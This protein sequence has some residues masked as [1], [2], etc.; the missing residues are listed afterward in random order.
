MANVTFLIDGNEVPVMNELD[1]AISK[2]IADIREPDKRNTDFSNT[3]EL[4][5]VGDVNR[6]FEHAFKVNIAHQTFNPNLKT[7]FSYQEDGI[8]IIGGYLKLSR[9]RVNRDKNYVIYE[10][11]IKGFFSDLFYQ[12][13]E[14]YLTDL[15]FSEYDHDLT[16]ANV[17]DSW[18]TTNIVNGS[19]VA[20]VAGIGYRYGLAD[21]GY[22]NGNLFDFYVAGMRPILFEY[23]YLLKIFFNAGKTFTSNFLSGSL[24]KTNVTPCTEIIK[25]TPAQQAAR[26][27]Y[28]GQAGG[29]QTFTWPMSYSGTGWD[30]GLQD[31]VLIF[32]SDTA[33]F[34][35]STPP[36]YSTV[37][38]EWTVPE[39]RTYTMKLSV[40]LSFSVTGPTPGCYVDTYDANIYAQLQVF[41]GGIW[42]DVVNSNS[43]VEVAYASPLEQM[44]SLSFTQQWNAGDKFRIVLIHEVSNL[45][46]RDSGGFPVVAGVV[47]YDLYDYEYG[48][49]VETNPLL[50][51]TT[52][53]FISEGDL[54]E[55]NRCIPT[56]IKQTD[57][58][59]GII[60]KYNLY[61]EIDKNDPNNYIIEPR[62]DFIQTTDPLDWTDKLDIGKEILISPRAAG[63]M[64]GMDLMYKPDGDY[65]NKSYQDSY[66]LPYGTKQ[67]R[68]DNQFNTEIKKI[69]LI[70]S[71]T[72]LVGNDSN[73]LI[74]PK[75]YKNENGVVSPMKCNIR[76]AL[77]NPTLVPLFSGNWRL[78]SILSGDTVYYS[79]PYF[80]HLDHPYTP[81]IDLCFD[82][83]ID[84]FYRVFGPVT[85]TGNDI[86][87]IY[88]KDMFLGLTDKDSKT[89]LAYFNLSS[90]DIK[91]FTFRK[92]IFVEDAYYLCNS[93]NDFKIQ[94]VG[95]TQVELLKLP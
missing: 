30:T 27:F 14:K 87:E 52:P 6:I 13:N 75:I 29:P 41:T 18:E 32:N 24:F 68:S 64:K 55:M 25:P 94:Q 3:I 88:Y 7:S 11:E 10:C 34:F 9:M 72:P 83:P 59:K 49:S 80:G 93:I 92:R 91:N 33:P 74:I 42:V 37:T 82:A 44:F 21:Y 66:T 28:A 35:N 20:L 56:N 70:F 43:F 90:L 62:F 67:V 77:W 15:D 71:P 58:L 57:Y 86:Y 46:L 22:N 78:K 12:I 85:Y 39:T 53:D 63:N 76:T 84:V 31:D 48:L 61:M 40:F 95:T 38:G 4:P 26:S 8:E 65:Y 36:M 69:E 51:V 19:P 81:T 1:I 79:Y 47:V 16:K 60:N 50:T 5:G 23:E 45:I 89:V 17:V 73:G 2:L 54:L